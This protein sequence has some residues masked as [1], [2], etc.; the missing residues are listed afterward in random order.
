VATVQGTATFNANLNPSVAID[1]NAALTQNL[2][3]GLVFFSCFHLIFI[4]IPLDVQLNFSA[5]VRWDIFLE[6]VSV[7]ME[8]ISLLFGRSL[9][10]VLAHVIIGGGKSDFG[11]HGHFKKHNWQACGTGHATGNK[12]LLILSSNRSSIFRSQDQ[13]SSES[14]LRLCSTRYFWYSCYNSF[15]NCV[16]APSALEGKDLVGCIEDVWYFERV[17]SKYAA[18]IMCLYLFAIF[19][20]WS[21]NLTLGNIHSRRLHNEICWGMLLRSFEISHIV[22]KIILY[23]KYLLCGRSKFCFP[24]F[25]R[26]WLHAHVKV[27]WYGL[28]W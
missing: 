5:R 7:S 17:A 15:I 9:L 25:W 26:S 3:R 11:V 20:S 2:N 22:K 28:N 13:K 6:Q 21:E 23:R 19:I 10:Y 1:V 16:Y 12:Y 4:V 18:G 8:I 14:T 27:W 24:N